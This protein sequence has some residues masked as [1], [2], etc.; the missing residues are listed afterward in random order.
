MKYFSFFQ[1]YCRE[2]VFHVVKV[3][4]VFCNQHGFCICL[5]NGASTS[6]AGLGFGDLMEPMKF[7]EIICFCAFSSEFNVQVFPDEGNTIL[8][9]KGLVH[10][11]Q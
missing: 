2:D 1:D 6:L 4:F 11:Y 5:M 9:V 3:T 7:L 8:V 10:F